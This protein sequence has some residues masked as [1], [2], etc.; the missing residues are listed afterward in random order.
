MT[1]DFAA[2]EE[3]RLLAEDIGGFFRMLR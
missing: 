1:R 3:P 2:M